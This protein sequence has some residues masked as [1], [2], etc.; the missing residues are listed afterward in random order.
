MEGQ[1]IINKVAKALK[2]AIPVGSTIVAAVS[3]GADSM[4][5]AEGLCQLEQEEY[6]CVF[7]LHVE[8][9]LRG[10]EA[11]RDA[12]LVEQFCKAKGLAFCC[13]HVDVL[14]YSKQAGISVES[15][16]RTLR[17]QA[18][19]AHA[20]KV[21]ADWIVTAHH[22]D[23]QAETILLKLLR[24]AGTAGLSGMSERNGRILRPF[25][26]LTRVELETYCALR[27][28][29]YCH[30]SSND[31]VYYTR[32]RVRLQLLPYLEQNFNP[33]IKKALVQTAQLLKE[34]EEY[35]AALVEQEFSK[36]VSWQ[37]DKLLL[38]TCV[39]SKLAKPVRTRLLRRAYFAAGGTELG[40][41]HTAALDKL[42]LN[43][44]SGQRLQL[45]Q[46]LQ[47]V[48]EYEKLIFS[49][50]LNINAVQTAMTE[51]QLPVQDGVVVRIETGNLHIRLLQEKP[52]L[53]GKNIIYPAKLVNEKLTVRC[54]KNGDRF[55]PY[56][57]SGGKKLKDYFID[58]KIPRQQRDSKLL[59]CC[60][61]RILGIFGVANGAWQP[62]EYDLWLDIEYTAKEQNNE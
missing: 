56:G 14:Q 9:G 6:C 37:Q 34:D 42:C 15:A 1:R 29:N 2:K 18:L 61:S 28:V 62:G 53:T 3:G 52:V 51:V 48:Y 22:S 32:N 23:D 24:G 43:N 44:R 38:S 57:G 60:G 30:D 49:K 47:A 16:A 11:L 55:Y 35:F 46:K 5:L 12:Q 39:W 19:E 36:R 8:H 21:K 41:K 10:D 13:Q 40:Y 59:V 45:P 7:V 17:Y 33:E 20:D 26:G 50:Q 4:A 58:R 27:K 31:D 25:L 54:R